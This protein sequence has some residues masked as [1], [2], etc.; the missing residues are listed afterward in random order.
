M[1]D[2]NVRGSL[3]AHRVDRYRERQRLLAEL[4]G[5]FALTFV[6]AG[7][8]V[9]GA[10]VPGGVGRAAAVTAPGLMVL[11]L[12]YTVGDVSG[13]HLNPAVSLAFAIRRDFPWRRLPGYWVAQAIGAI[14]AAAVLRALFGTAGHVGATL[15]AHGGDVRSLVMEIVLTWLLVT[16]ILGTSEGHKLV[17]HNAAIAVGGYVALAGLFASPISGASMNPARSLGPDLLGGTMSSFWIYLVAP[18]IGA[19][20]AVGLAAGLHG[21]ANQYERQAA[22]GE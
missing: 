3:H 2:V 4:V 22:L 6:A 7:G 13:A 15:P 17:G 10:V 20:L 9:L 8:P 1:P 5:T 11:A 12:I 14:V 19:L 18:V 21:G 16:V